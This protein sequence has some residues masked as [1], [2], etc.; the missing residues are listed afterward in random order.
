VTGAGPGRC[1]AVAPAPGRA[2]PPE[3]PITLRPARAG[4]AA[5]LARVDTATS[6]Q[7]WTE[8]TFL[9][10]VAHPDRTYVV[11]CAGAGASQVNSDGE[12]VGYAGLAFLAGDAHVMGL[13]V[14]PSAQGRGYGRLLLTAVCRAAAAADAAMTLEVRPSNEVARRL[15]RS[16][17]FIE[18]GRRPG[19]Y[20]DGEDAL[21][22][23]RH[24][25][26]TTI[27]ALTTTDA[28]PATPATPTTDGG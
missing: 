21:I 20:P 4:D 27:P 8:A 24:V 2:T 14:L 28:T 6:T 26:D 5:A 22:L 23:W 7:P 9:T 1:G 19:Y 12:V 18:A 3:R 25:T 16:V 15:Y 10:E 17:G 13:A 11:A